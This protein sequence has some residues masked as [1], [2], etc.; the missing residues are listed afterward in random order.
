M[1]KWL[2]NKKSLIDRIDSLENDLDLLIEEVGEIATYCDKCEENSSECFK[3]KGTGV[4]KKK[5]LCG[6]QW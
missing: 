2:K 1:F 5:Q 6:W 3:C 4:I